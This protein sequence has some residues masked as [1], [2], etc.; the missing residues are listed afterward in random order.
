MPADLAYADSSGHQDEV[1][2]DLSVQ[3]G[4]SME[5][6]SL[7]EGG[8]FHPSPYQPPS[9]GQLFFHAFCGNLTAQTHR[10]VY[11]TPQPDAF[12][13]VIHRGSARVA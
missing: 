13:Y 2:I 4:Y 11:C 7:S 1:F 6:P 8:I 10:E 3:G 9:N 12:K 5:D